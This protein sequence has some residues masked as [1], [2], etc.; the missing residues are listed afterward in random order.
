M[1]LYQ[2]GFLFKFNVSRPPV[3]TPKTPK[4]PKPMIHSPL[5]PNVEKLS[6]SNVEKP[7][8]PKTDVWTSWWCELRGTVLKCWAID[9]TVLLSGACIY[10]TTEDDEIRAIKAK[11]T[12]PNFIQLADACVAVK[13]KDPVPPSPYAQVPDVV[14]Q[15]VSTF[16]P[17]CHAFKVNSSGQNLHT[18]LAP[19]L[20]FRDAWVAAIRYFSLIYAKKGG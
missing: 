13:Q 5:T 19:S 14:L 4:T 16:D 17:F 10:K 2:A 11:Q 7:A 1:T 12:M 20:H 18:F 6:T 3:F 9:A 15:D 8:L